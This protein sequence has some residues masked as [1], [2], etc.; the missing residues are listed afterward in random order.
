[1]VGLIVAE[2]CVRVG[3]TGRVEDVAIVC[4]LL[5]RRNGG[6]TLEIGAGGLVETDRRLPFPGLSHGCGEVYHGVGDLRP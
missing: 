3:G 2:P 5:G 1:M 6:E 4:G